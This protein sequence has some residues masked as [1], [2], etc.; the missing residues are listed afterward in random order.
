MQQRARTNIIFEEKK[1]ASQKVQQQWSH[2]CISTNKT[3]FIK[4][5]V[6][7]LKKK[8][9]RGKLHGKDLSHVTCRLMK[10]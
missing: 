5:F 10:D 6:D 7:G 2:L 1:A 8:K 4:L 9:Y 3:S